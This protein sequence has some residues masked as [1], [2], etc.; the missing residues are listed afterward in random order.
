MGCDDNGGVLT[1]E[2]KKIVFAKFD[3]DKNGYIDFE[4]FLE[5]LR[6]FLF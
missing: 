1:K 4:E 6:V 5:Q 2:E 3:K